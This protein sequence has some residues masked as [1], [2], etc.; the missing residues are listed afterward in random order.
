MAGFL[1]SQHSAL[2]D[3]FNSPCNLSNWQNITQIEGWMTPGG[4]PAEHLEEHDISFTYPGELYMMPWTSSWYANWRGVLL[5]K[6]I[7][8]NFI[9]TTHITVTQRDGDALPPSSDY[10]LAGLMIRTP[11]GIFNPI[12]GGPSGIQNYIFAAMGRATS[13]T[14]FQLEIKTT[15]NGASML[16]IQNIGAGN[17]DIYMR[18]VRKDSVVVV[19]SSEDNLNWRLRERFL[20]PDFPDTVQMGF[21]TYTDWDNVSAVGW[22]EQNNNILNNNYDARPWDPDLIGRFEFA[23]FEALNLDSLY[24]NENFMILDTSTI[25]T[26]FD[27]SSVPIYPAGSKIWSGI[28]SND[29]TDPGN[30]H[31]GLPGTG[32]HVVIPNCSCSNVNS[33]FINAD[34]PVLA[35]FH[36]EEGAN[37]EISPAVTLQVDLQ[38]P[39]SA[40]V[41]QGNITNYGTILINNALGR[42]VATLSSLNNQPGAQLI[43]EE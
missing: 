42:D 2:N 23:R 13:S 30:W 7:S 40:F 28:S 17:N 36:L 34:T 14:Q 19:L 20:R 12:N 6:E 3:E 8:G 5:F 31:G 16:G 22:Q 33:L 38:N 29:W 21:V 43:I 1:W 32:D 10:S 11:T 9:V 27:H 25:R 41:N 37:M 24:E 26:L 18:M 39:G 15:R 35:G 4:Q